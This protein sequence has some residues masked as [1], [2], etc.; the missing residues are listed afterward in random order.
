MSV[1]A[2]PAEV[3]PKIEVRSVSVSG[4]SLRG[5]IWWVPINAEAEI[6]AQ[7]DI[8]DCEMMFISERVLDGS[9]PIDDL[10][11]IATIQAGPMSVRVKFPLSGNYVIS[12]KRLNDGLKRIEAPFQ[13]DF[14]NV[15]FDAY[16]T[17]DPL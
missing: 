4:A 3:L 6:T 5:K 10:R 17:L 2:F 13:L 8:P 14:E 1:I 16:V 12:A 9:K 7:V 15:E 11:F